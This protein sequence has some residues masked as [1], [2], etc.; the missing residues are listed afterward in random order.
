MSCPARRMDGSGYRKPEDPDL[1]IRNNCALAEL[2]A[3][4]EAQDAAIYG[5][6][7]GGA[8]A[9]KGPDTSLPPSIYTTP[10]SDTCFEVDGHF[11]K[12]PDVARAREIQKSLE[13]LAA[14]REKEEAKWAA[15]WK[16]VPQSV[17][18]AWEESDVLMTGP[19]VS[20]PIVSE[21]L[22]PET[23]T[24]AEATNTGDLPQ[25]EVAELP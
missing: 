17:K 15:Y 19:R 4:R 3:A 11:Y 22:E 21:P 16:E 24:E 18:P 8:T 5:A 10:P 2:M 20:E 23:K 13:E 7:T 1:E 14:E 12:I 25:I 9:T 6:W